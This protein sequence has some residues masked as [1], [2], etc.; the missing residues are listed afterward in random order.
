MA[1]EGGDVDLSLPHGHA[2]VDHIAAG[3]ASVGSVDVRIVPP[4]LGA[5]PGVEG[6]YHSPGSRRKED[7]IDDD[8]CGLEAVGRLSPQRTGVI[9]PGQAQLLDVLGLDQAEGRIV[10]LTEIAAERQPA[11]GLGVSREQPFDVDPP[12]RRRGPLG[13]L[14][15]EGEAKGE[16]VHCH[17]QRSHGS[18]PSVVR[19]PPGFAGEAP[20]V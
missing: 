1:V 14:A 4:D 10:R 2:P 7:A 20:R 13:R 9:L 8:G 18:P 5:G 17:K 15:T 16:Q 3:P 19:S 12:R 11:L 6:V